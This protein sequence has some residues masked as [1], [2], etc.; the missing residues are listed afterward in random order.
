MEK[1]QETRT[2]DLY[3]HSKKKQHKERTEYLYFM[4]LTLQP[5]NWSNPSVWTIINVHKLKHTTVT[6][7]GVQSTNEERN[8]TGQKVQGIPRR[9]HLL[10][11]ILTKEDGF[12][13]V[14][15]VLSYRVCRGTT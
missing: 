11:N 4:S 9:V 12:R 2:E 5:G 14:I 7:V 13:Y 6:I 15:G 1:E 8:K 3:S 10:N